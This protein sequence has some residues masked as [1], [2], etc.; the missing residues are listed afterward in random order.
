MFAAGAGA[1]FI[2][3]LNGDDPCFFRGQVDRSPFCV[4]AP[5]ER[6]P[7]RACQGLAIR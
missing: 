3:A 1:A 4:F 2:M 5:A 6:L 7:I